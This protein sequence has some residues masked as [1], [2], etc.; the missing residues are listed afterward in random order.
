MQSFS[1]PELAANIVGP[2][3][4]SA[5][6]IQQPKRKKLTRDEVF[7]QDEDEDESEGPKKRKLVPL[8]YTEEERRV[9]PVP[10][11]VPMPR[12]TTAEEKRRCIKNLIERIPTAKEELFAFPLD[13]AMVDSVSVLCVIM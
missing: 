4:P 8:D 6:D 3:L 1:V 10:P 2:Q 7:N 9:A 5:M 12:P 13:W 11:I